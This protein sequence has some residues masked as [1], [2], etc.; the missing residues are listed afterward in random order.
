MPSFTQI[1][2]LGL[3]GAAG[4]V[5]ASPPHI[6]TATKPPTSGDKST[7]AER[8][9]PSYVADMTHGQPTAGICGAGIPTWDVA[10][11]PAQFENGA[12]C[13]LFIRLWRN[14]RLT[15]PVKVV[16]KCSSCANGSVR[17]TD[18]IWKELTHPSMSLEHATVTWSFIQPSH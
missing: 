8:E 9:S 14:D 4:C 10:L 6:A 12:S 13:G 7:T 11:S 3:A 16:D 1:I 2:L 17:V 5:F 15:L 18:E